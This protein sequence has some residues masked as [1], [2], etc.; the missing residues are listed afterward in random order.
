NSYKL[1]LHTSHLPQISRKQVLKNPLRV[2]YD[3]YQ[4]TP[5]FSGRQVSL[6]NPDIKSVTIGQHPEKTRVV[7]TLKHP[8]QIH[9]K[10]T[11]EGFELTLTP[12]SKLVQKK[13]NSRT[14]Q[15]TRTSAHSIKTI[16]NKVIVIDPGH[17]GW[18][19]GA[20][21]G[22]NYEKKYTLDISK[23]LEKKLSQ[24]GAKVIMCRT[25]DTNP[26]L[27]QRT[28]LANMNRADI[29][30]SIHVNS[31]IKP[32]A[33]GVE[34]YYYKPIDKKLSRLVHG[35]MVKTLKLRNNGLKKARMYILNHSRMPGVLVEPCFL[36]N[37]KEYKLIQ[38]AQFRQKIA[39]SIFLGVSK[40]FQQR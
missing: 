5:L 6:D 8:M 23:R 9:S 10:S 17:G 2:Y 29:L 12:F 38:T 11:N 35:E 3:F 30:I 34:T 37:P 4:T 1:Q 26:S 22:S 14:A 36:T 28:K 13:Q 24:H 32:Y 33:N 40:Y 7:F 18:D 19:P 16:K 15:P 39:D 25:N 31:F 27:Y 20:V 21:R